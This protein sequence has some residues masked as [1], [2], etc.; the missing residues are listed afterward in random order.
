MPTFHFPPSLLKEPFLKTSSFYDTASPLPIDA[1]FVHPM[2]LRQD[3]VWLLV[4]GKTF[5]SFA[6]KIA[7]GE[8]PREVLGRFREGLGRILF[9]QEFS[10]A[11]ITRVLQAFDG[12][13]RMEGRIAKGMRRSLE[14]LADHYRLFSETAALQAEE[15]ETVSLL[16]NETP[17]EMIGHEL[18]SE[19]FR[20]LL[21]ASFPRE[22]GKAA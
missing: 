4:H 3:F 6:L 2:K 1:W 18:P 15:N 16:V 21:A 7:A 13:F 10:P 22:R 8:G 9:D 12:E 5:Y 20:S 17:L 11:E 19:A 14:V